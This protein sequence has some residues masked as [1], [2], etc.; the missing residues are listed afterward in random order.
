MTPR[1]FS[2]DP[3]ALHLPPPAWIVRPAARPGWTRKTFALGLHLACLGVFGLTVVWPV[4][5]PVASGE[6]ARELAM[7]QEAAQAWITALRGHGL[8]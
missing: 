2:I 1:C 7:L 8:R 3:D 4:V 5:G 6:L